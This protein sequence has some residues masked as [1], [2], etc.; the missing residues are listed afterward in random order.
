MIR[1]VE[2][3]YRNGKVELTETPPQVEEARVVVTF[4]SGTV[5]L[6]DHGISVDLSQR[7]AV[8]AVEAQCV[9][10]APF[11]FVGGPAEH[12]LGDACAGDVTAHREFVD[13]A[14]LT[15]R[16]LRPEHRVV[17]G[18]EHRNDRAI[19]Y[20]AEHDLAA[21]RTRAQ[22]GFGELI[23]C[24]QRP[25]RVD[26]PLRCLAQN[27]LRVA[28]VADRRIVDPQVFIHTRRHDSAGV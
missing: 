19:V 24:P 6:R 20:T 27:R 13:V 3:I 25:A 11:R 18:Q 22:V 28:P 10:A 7:R 16:N 15:P 14:G 4:L 21:P 17:P 26:Q 8:V 12:L 9:A 2:G 23:Q 5:D 1:A